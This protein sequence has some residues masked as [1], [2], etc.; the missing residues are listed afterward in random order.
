MAQ[1]R[2]SLGLA[3]GGLIIIA[4]LVTSG[5][6]NSEKGNTAALNSNNS[7]DA[8]AN[9]LVVPGNDVSASGNYAGEDDRGEGMAA[10]MEREHH[11]EM[12]HRDMRM[13][14]RSRGNADE[15]DTQADNQA[16]PMNH[17]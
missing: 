13:G 1:K 3:A 17:M 4:A 9:N 5:C 16:M 6:N 7:V 14:D 10:D 11:Q 12:D 2:N 8:A 15:P